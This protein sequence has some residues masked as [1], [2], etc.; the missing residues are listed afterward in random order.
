MLQNL[1]YTGKNKDMY[2]LKLDLQKSELSN[3][4]YNLESRKEHTSK[5]HRRKGKLKLKCQ[6]L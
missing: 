1:W 3:R 6:F 5:E 4:Q 2:R